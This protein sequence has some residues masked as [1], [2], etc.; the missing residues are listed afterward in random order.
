[1]LHRRGA[2]C[3]GSPMNL[4][5]VPCMKNEVEGVYF[6]T[7]SLQMTNSWKGNSREFLEA[8]NY[9]VLDFM[10]NS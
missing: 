1:M 2:I 8:R 10:T 4:D 6:E 3:Y 7:L 5:M 9:P